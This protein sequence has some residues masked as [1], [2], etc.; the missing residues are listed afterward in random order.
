[1]LGETVLTTGSAFAGEPFGQ[2]RLLALAIA[3][4]GTV[5]LWWCY[6]QRAEALGAQAAESAE[7]VG[8]VGRWGTWSLTLIVLGLIPIAVADELAIANPGDD[9]TL[10]FTILAFGGPALFLLSQLLFR[11][12]AAPCVTVTCARA[13]GTRDPRRGRCAVFAHRRDR[14]VQRRTHCGGHRGY[15]PAARS[16]PR[17]QVG[18]VVG[19]IHQQWRPVSPDI[20][21]RNGRTDLSAGRPY[22]EFRPSVRRQF[23]A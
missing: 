19:P 10:G 14:G 4:A 9:A 12:G 2:E 11:H 15:G 13:R 8:A 3:F 20:R 22:V 16:F 5:A 17:E 23:F 21:G 6:F 7:D 18:L 1:V